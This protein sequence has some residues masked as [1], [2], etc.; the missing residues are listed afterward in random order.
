MGD[1]ISDFVQLSLMVLYRCYYH[2][3]VVSAWLSINEYYLGSV[4]GGLQN[5]DTCYIL[6]GNLILLR[7]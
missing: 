7:F 1:E 2:C 3:L 4:V 6:Y 5:T